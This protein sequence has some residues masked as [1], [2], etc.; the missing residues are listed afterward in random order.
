P[1]NLNGTDFVPTYL[2]RT[3]HRFR[4]FLLGAK[5]GTAERAAQRLSA[6]YP[7]HEIVGCQH[8]YFDTRQVSPIV[9]RIRQTAADLV[10]VAMGNPKQELF[11]QENLEATGCRLGMGVGALFDFLAGSVR[12][13]TPGIRRWHLE[14]AYR[15]AQEPGRLVG[16]YLVGV[17]VFLVRV[18]GQWWS[19]SCVDLG[20]DRRPSTVTA[21]GSALTQRFA[22]VPR[23]SLPGPN[24]C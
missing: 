20:S 11:I 6:L 17:P 16:R 22:G 10:L 19:G 5:P 24:P 3:K 18:L 1:A 15:L 12:R 14:W 2:Q 8:G 7:R 13:A 21:H 4:I 9:A 23:S